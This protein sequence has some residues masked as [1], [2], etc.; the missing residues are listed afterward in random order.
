M[1]S[2]ISFGDPPQLVVHHDKVAVE[3]GCATV[4][5]IVVCLL[6]ATDFKFRKTKSQTKQVQLR[7]AILKSR[8]V[9]IIRHTRGDVAQLMKHGQLQ[10]A[11]FR[12]EQ[13]YKDQ[14]LVLAYDQM[15]DFCQVIITNMPEIVRNSSSLDT[16]PAELREA[17]ATLTY[18]AS[19]CGK[20]PEL[21]TL[22]TMFRERYGYKFDY[23]NVELLP[24]NNVNSE[25][26]DNLCIK[27]VPESVKL[28][29]INE[30]SETQNLCGDQ[31]ENVGTL[32][33]ETSSIE[34]NISESPK[35]IRNSAM[36]VSSGRAEISRNRHLRTST[37]IPLS[38]HYETVRGKRFSFESAVNNWRLLDG[39]SCSKH[40]HPKLPEYEDFVA[41][42]EDI[43]VAQG[44]DKRFQY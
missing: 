32:T 31:T 23:T 36:E 2:A 25:M 6:L 37:D 18:A 7:L 9:A 34:E 1:E 13:V 11:S 26:R 35:L 33:N 28:V 5:Y 4:I 40:F 22:R 17:L 12:V 42:F 3:K 15:H 14:K 16:L 43:K 10:Q 20:L 29:L 27:S 41:K 19:R 39:D 8:E 24:G 44:L 38:C 30:I 21:Q